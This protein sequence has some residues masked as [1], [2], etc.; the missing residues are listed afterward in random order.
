MLFRSYHNRIK[1]LISETTDLADGQIYFRNADRVA[2]RGMELELEGR[3][4]AGVQGRVSYNL[5]SAEDQKTHKILTNSPQHLGQLK[6]GLPLAGKALQL[7]LEINYMGARMTLNGNEAPAFTVANLTLLTHRLP[8][9]WEASFS[10]YNLLD[11]SYGDPGAEEHRQDVL[12]QDGRSLRF[13]LT[14][15]FPRPR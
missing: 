7:G 9:G 12:L 1:G 4:A 13:K 3:T 14:C 2:A 10:I 8:K 15:T 6:L 5:Q 11:K